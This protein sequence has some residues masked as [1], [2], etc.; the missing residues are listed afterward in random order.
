MGA[1]YDNYR[2]LVVGAQIQPRLGLAYSID[3]T[4]TVLRAS[5]NRNFQTPPNENLLLSN[6]DQAAMLAPPDVRRDLNGGVILMRAQR[7]NVF[8][9]GLQQRL[10]DWGSLNAVYYHKHS[11]DLQDND[12][13]LNTGI[14]FPTSLARSRVNGFETRLSVPNFRRFTGS[15]SLTHYHIVVTPPF[16]G[17]LFLGNQRPRGSQRRAVYHRSRPAAG[18]QRPGDVP[19]S[20]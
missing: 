9:G 11:N 10:G 3:E 19:P 8:E 17:G 15:L 1:R 4:G 14:I 2:F 18:R 13:F 5:Y 12:N 7:Q 6:S 20:A 16:T